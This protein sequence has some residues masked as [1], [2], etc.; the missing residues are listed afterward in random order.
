MATGGA[1][2]ITSWG[3]WATDGWISGAMDACHT[4]AAGTYTVSHLVSNG[5]DADTSH[6]TITIFPAP[7]IT[8]TPDTSLCLPSGVTAVQ[9]ILHANTMSA[10]SWGSTSANYLIGPATIAHPT[11]TINGPAPSVATIYVDVMD[12]HGCY[13]TDS[14]VVHLAICSGIEDAE[15]KSSLLAYPNPFTNELYISFTKENSALAQIDLIDVLGNIVYTQAYNKS[16][17]YEIIPTALL[18]SGVYTLQVKTDNG[19][20]IARK[21]LK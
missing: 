20:K 11:L 12:G 2:A 19:V 7:V 17:V 8:M 9:F 15:I 3:W 14:S 10:Y 5:T 18:P 4:F 6:Q 13:A 1:A 21:L 16:A